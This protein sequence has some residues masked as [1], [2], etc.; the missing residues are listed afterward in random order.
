LADDNFDR[1]AETVDRSYL[2]R[3]WSGLRPPARIGILAVGSLALILIAVL[4]ISRSAPPQM[5][6]LFNRLDPM[7]ANEIAAALDEMVVPYE[8]A[9][10][11]TTILV[12]SDQRD[13]LRLSL[14]PDLYAQGIGFALFENGGLVASDFERRVQWQIALEEELR[15]TITSIDAV[16]QARI[17][18][19]ITEEGLFIREKKDPSASVFLKLRPLASLTEAQVRGILSLVAGSVEG[20]KPENVTIIDSGGNILYDAFASLDGMSASTL[21]EGQLQMKRQFET[22]LERR[23]RSILEQVYGPGKA[24]AMVSADLDFDTRETTTV[25]FDDN[26]VTRST[27]R[28]EERSENMAAPAGEVGEPNIPGQAAVADGGG[29][30]SYERTEEIVNYEVSETRQYIAAAPGQVIRL[31]TAVIIDNPG[32]DPFLEEQ[33]IDLVNSAIGLDAERGDT[34][35]VQLLPFDTSWLGDVDSDPGS[36]L[37]E[38]TATPLLW[39]IIGAAVLLLALLAVFFVMRSRARRLEEEEELDALSLEEHL[40]K[41]A[42]QQADKIEPGEAETKAQEIRRLAK[43]EPESVASL[44]KTWLAEE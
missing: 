2:I 20:L 9:D 10:D 29:E 19:V 41:Q 7:Q 12:P 16:E 17:H 18:L 35:S 3:L 14:S 23:L 13:R 36:L 8:L 5:D 22:E 34:V 26:P 30:S 31:S 11:G 28:I 37:P 6:V 42:I 24:V 4:S 44:L 21:L 1:T 43:E 25:V 32:N 39:T 38:V 33:V 27:H 40:R 15:R